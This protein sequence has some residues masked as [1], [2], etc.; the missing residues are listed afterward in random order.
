MSGIAL[1]S[2]LGSFDY[3][4]DMA[5]DLSLFT[6]NDEIVPFGNMLDDFVN[7]EGGWSEDISLK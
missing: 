3:G 7:I 1:Q 2:H 5:I 6:V 4:E